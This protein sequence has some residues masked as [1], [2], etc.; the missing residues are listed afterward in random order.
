MEPGDLFVEGSMGRAVFERVRSVVESMG[1]VEI[2]TSKSQ[3]AFRRRR[4]F[5]YLWSPRQYLGD[6]GVEVVLAIVL[7]R[8]DESDRFKEVSHPS[9]AHWM[10]HIEVL[11]V[12]DV[13]AEVEDW[14]REAADGAD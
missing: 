9:P 7:H 1:P 8:H 11:D 14:L 3:I 2:R 4:G 5:A 13:D 12:A 6:A 10:H